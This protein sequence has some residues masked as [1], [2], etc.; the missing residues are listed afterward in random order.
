MRGLFWKRILKPVL[1]ALLVVMA[2]V[3][4]IVVFLTVTEYRPK[5]TE[6]LDITAKVSGK[7]ESD[8]SELPSVRVGTSLSILTWNIGY[9]ALGDNADFFMDGGSSVFTADSQRVHENI[10]GICKEIETLDPDFVFLQE[11]DVYSD[12]SRHVNEVQTLRDSFTE[13][14]GESGAS[15]FAYNFKVKFIPYPVPPIGRVESGIF[16]LS[17]YHITD[18]E[19]VQ[20]PCPFSWPVRTANLKRCLMVDR[21]PVINASGENTGRELVLVNLHLE[22]YDSG[23]G[24]TA[25]TKMLRTLLQEEADKGNYVIAGGDFNQTFS[26]T[27]DSMYPEY[28]GRWHCGEIEESE[29]DNGWQFL[30]DN[31]VPTC[32]SLDQ[33]YKGK[34]DKN[35]QFYMIDGF[36]V[37]SNVHVDTLQTQ[38]LKFKNS[39]HNPVLLGV[40]L[41]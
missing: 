1:I 7:E 29:F 6:A 32:R 26:G 31:T 19:R 35:F 23:E 11:A 41:R 22:A 30:M 20:L 36:I 18:S 34:S 16:T 12:R 17:K 27:D 5:D 38:D 13:N 8:T 33:S 2:L 37:S 39:D 21:I 4:V 15:T 14:N 24:K 25:Q 28:E 40:E 10:S 9:G 3:A